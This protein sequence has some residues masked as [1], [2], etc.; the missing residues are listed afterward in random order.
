MATHKQHEAEE[1][2]E[3]SD[4]S[5]ESPSR[6]F[7]PIATGEHNE[8]TRTNSMS[9]S[10]QDSQAMIH[11]D[12]RRELQR[13]ATELSRRRSSIQGDRPTTGTL[14]TVDEHD[15]AYD[16]TSKDFNLEKWIKGVMQKLGEEGITAK[17]TGVTYKNLNVSGSGSALQL[18]QTVGG[19]LMAPARLGEFFSFGK[20]EPKHILRNFDGVLKSGELLIVLGRPGS[21]C[22]TLLKSLTGQLHGLTLDEKSVIHYNG[23]P[24]EKMIK[25]F[26]GEI[27]YNQEACFTISC[28]TYL[29]ILFDIGR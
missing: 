3:F 1:E 18:Q 10:R 24:Q 28:L 23:I 13:I 7:A 8:T 6:E 9:L 21:G 19:Y 14:G 11:D 16:P 20:K 27:V 12:D 29:L 25:Q 5:S 15:P 26:K 17:K 2:V 22:S 4:Y